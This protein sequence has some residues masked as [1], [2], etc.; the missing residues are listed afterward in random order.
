MQAY[1]I[2]IPNPEISELVQR[3]AFYLGYKWFGHALEI[4]N[5]NSDCLYFNA[6]SF[7]LHSPIGYFN[8]PSNTE[9]EISYQ[10]FLKLGEQP[11]LINNQIQQQMSIKLKCFKAPQKAKNITVGKE[12][13]GVYIDGDDTQVDSLADAEYFQ[14]I[15]NSGVEAKY[16]LSLF[17]QPAIPAIPEPPKLTMDQAIEA[18]IIR[19]GDIVLIHNG[20]T[21]TLSNSGTRD[22]S[23][24]RVLCSCGIRAIDGIDSAYECI[25]DY[26]SDNFDQL[27]D[28][29]ED[30]SD[31]RFLDLVFEKLLKTKIAE[32]S[33]AFVLLSTTEANESVCTLMDELFISED[34]FDDEKADNLTPVVA[35]NPNSDNNIRVWLIKK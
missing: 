17:D 14:C 30:Y 6:Q 19:A 9:T 12:Y 5:V 10:D 4:S 33:A 11:E 2:R 3:K 35:L 31:L 1:K 20:I 27:N 21:I 34:P 28:I 16:R 32:V 23:N 26:N 25:E 24:D 18:T 13:N 15:N 22:L 7:I 8:H 29:I